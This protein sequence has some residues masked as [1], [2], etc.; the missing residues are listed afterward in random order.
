MKLTGLLRAAGTGLLLLTWIAASHLGSTGRGPADL[1]V[2]V[3]LAPLLAALALLLAQLPRP[4]LKWLAGGAAALLLWALWPWLRGQVA[5]LY[6][7]QHLGVH[8]ALA[9]LFGA[10]L[11]RPAD[12]LITRMARAVQGRDLSP[13]LLRYT[14]QST[15]A[16]TVFFLLNAAV[17]TLLFV[18][19]PR[20]LWSLHANVLTG[21]LLGSMFVLDAL[22]RQAVLL[23]HER[24]R[25]SDVLR[26]WRDDS[27]RRQ[28]AR[29]HP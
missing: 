13:R 4:A 9:L 5:L 28:A 16:W 10:T 20:D 29:S 8:L 11:V 27:K 12:P 22:W 26:A 2:A 25:L 6:Y 14:R 18:A 23:P 24:P 3:A 15:A 1:H 21:P 19:A 17:S 7:L